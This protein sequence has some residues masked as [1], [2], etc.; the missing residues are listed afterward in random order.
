MGGDGDDKS[1]TDLVM[2]EAAQQATHKM[3]G[4]LIGGGAAVAGPVLVVLIAAVAGLALLAGVGQWAT[5]LLGP[6]PPAIATPLSRPAEWLDAITMGGARD[7]VPN[8][9]G[10]AVVEQ[11]SDGQVYGD[12]YYCSNQQSA[13]APCPTVFH[14]GLLGIGSHG[15]TT[16]GVGVGLMGLDSRRV[17]G[18]T[19]AVTANLG[20]GLA[21]LGA[22]LRTHPD[23]G[24]ALAAFHVDTQTPPGWAGS[25]AYA[26][27]VEGLVQRYD[28]GPHLGAWALAPW[29]HQTGAFEDPGHTPEWVFAVGV[30]PVGARGTWVTAPGSGTVTRTRSVCRSVV[31]TTPGTTRVV[32]L[33]GPHGRLI[34]RMVTT[35]GTATT[36]RTCTV[37]TVQVPAPGRVLHYTDVGTPMQV[38]GTTAQGRQVPFRF[39]PQDPAVPVWSGGAVWG[40]QVALTGPHRLT[41][42]S[43]EWPNGQMYTINWPEQASG[44]TGSGQVISDQAALQEW[45]PDIQTASAQTGV[46]AAWIAA[47]MLTESHGDRYAGAAGLQGAYG[48]MQLEPGTDGA[49]NADR[50]NPQENLT[51]GARYLGGLHQDTG[52]WRLASAAYYGGLGNLERAGWRPGMSWT[53]AQSLLARVV[54][55]PQ[56][57]NT[58]SLGG[59][60]ANIAATAH[61]V[62]THAPTTKG[63]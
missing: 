47:E 3:W 18:A 21:R 8:V 32:H 30:A 35:P 50:Q 5:G 40:A 38:W 27:T 17:P 15:V 39:S 60:A 53:Q 33:R 23:L 13:G 2:E 42:I 46:P 7:H 14:P 59:Y 10:L 54:P 36:H 49:T 45:W 12:R 1:F 52:S 55:D 31:T 63:G 48:L 43:A 57:G 26:A 6:S 51:F 34:T 22:A 44:A 4:W 58:L 11:A 41:L 56:A 37:R 61:W 19:H 16:R 29:S 25:G 62:T 28:A 24:Q 9:L 20:T